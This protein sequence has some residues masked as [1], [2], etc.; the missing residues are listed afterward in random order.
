MLG[1]SLQWLWHRHPSSV[2]CGKHWLIPSAPTP[3]GAHHHVFAMVI[4]HHSL[5]MIFLATPAS[6]ATGTL[7]CKKHRDRQ[8]S[9]DL[10]RYYLG[11]LGSYLT[12]LCASVSPAC[13][14]KIIMAS[15][16]SCAVKEKKSLSEK[17]LSS[18]WLWHV[19]TLPWW[20]G[21]SC[22]S[23]LTKLLS[24]LLLLCRVLSLPWLDLI[25]LSVEN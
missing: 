23:L 2:G 16:H 25:P 4:P 15:S 19:T 14:T 10:R 8:T 21:P 7:A 20:W 24:C 9:S 12:V 1:M 5:Q 13:R 18:S 6:I 17:C 22:L 11:S 3:Q